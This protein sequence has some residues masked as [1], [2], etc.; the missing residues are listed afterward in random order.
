VLCLF[1]AKND[2]QLA[3]LGKHWIIRGRVSGFDADNSVVILEECEV[4]P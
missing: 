2:S 4:V 3:K 1:S